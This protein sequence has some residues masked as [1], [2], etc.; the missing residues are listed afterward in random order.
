MYRR[1][2]Y[3]EGNGSS[4]FPHAVQEGESSGMETQKPASL[5][6]FHFDNLYYDQPMDLG[7]YLLVQVG[8]LAASTGF[9]CPLHTQIVYEIS[10]V[11]AGKG[12][13]RVNNIDYTLEKGMLFINHLQD[14]HTIISDGDDPIRYFYLGFSFVPDE[15]QAAQT[16]TLRHFFD[17]CEARVGIDDGYMRDAFLNLFAQLLAEDAFAQ[18]MIAACMHQI[19]VTA[20]RR[21]TDIRAGRAYSLGSRERKKHL[22]YDIIHYLDTRCEDADALKTLGSA[23]GYSYSYLS[24]IFTQAMK[25]S[26]Q[27]YYHARRFER[28]AKLLS[29]GM[30]VT[31]TADILGYASIHSFSRAFMQAVGCPPSAYMPAPIQQKQLKENPT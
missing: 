25:Q 31:Q 3:N 16:R 11:V 6:K 17:R 20:Y 9:I 13:F 14:T 19:I 10:Y 30:S 2:C 27:K 18:S 5:I 29:G 7:Q 1:L 21:C 15:R 12:L 4:R 23:L 28:A 8:D 24:D 26:L 22:L